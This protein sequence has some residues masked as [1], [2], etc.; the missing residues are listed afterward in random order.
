MRARSSRRYES[1]RNSHKKKSTKVPQC[2]RFEGKR[3]RELVLEGSKTNNFPCK[4]NNHFAIPVVQTQIRE[5]HHNT[6]RF[7]LSQA[8]RLY[9]TSE[10][11]EL[12]HSFILSLSLSPSLSLN[13]S[14]FRYWPP[15]AI[16]HRRE[17][18]F[19]SSRARTHTHTHTRMVRAPINFLE[20]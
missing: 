1:I 16:F 10:I 13:F 5:N 9:R 12:I 19:Y 7:V 17:A 18:K 6:D 14:T 3:L 8:S 20:K 11:R 4:T 2:I 15:S